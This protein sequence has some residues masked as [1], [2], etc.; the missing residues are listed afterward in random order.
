[1]VET[2]TILTTEAN[3]VLRPVHDR[4]PVILHTEDYE[5]W[6]ADDARKMGLMK[7]LLRPY[8]SSEMVSY[9][10]STLVNNTHNLGVNLLKPIQLNSA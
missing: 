10:V 5:L 7:E 2:C 4:M 6:L 3:E 1:M 9:P 8:P